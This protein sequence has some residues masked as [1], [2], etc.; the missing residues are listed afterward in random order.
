MFIDCSESSLRNK[1][2]IQDTFASLSNLGKLNYREIEFEY[3]SV[4]EF[5]RYVKQNIFGKIIILDRDGVINKRMEKRTYLT[6]SNQLE[7]LER[8]LELFR[9]LSTIGYNFVV[10][11]NQPGVAL[12]SVTESFLKQLHTRIT[13]DLRARGINVL[14]FYVCKHHWDTNCLCRKPKPGLL[15]EIVE[16]FKLHPTKHYSLATK[17]PMLRQ[18]IQRGCKALNSH[19]TTL[20]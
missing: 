19:L 12:G 20:M 17:L 9:L 3:E 16:D 5:P 18:L 15:N 11:T 6:K 1:K 7:Y 13:A 4:S 10:A 8:N 14:A 2:N